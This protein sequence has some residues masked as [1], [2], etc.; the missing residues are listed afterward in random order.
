MGSAPYGY[1]RIGDGEMVIVPEEAEIIQELAGRILAGDSLHQITS[2]L[3]E[4]RVP[5]TQG[6][7][8]QWARSTIKNLLR[9]PRNAGIVPHKGEPLRNDAGEFVKG[10]WEPILD[11]TTW[12]RVRGALDTAQRGP[13]PSKSLLAGYLRCGK[14]GGPLMGHTGT[15][16]SNRVYRCRSNR[17]DRCTNGVR[18]QASHIEGYVVGYV[19]ES[20][21]GASR[22]LHEPNA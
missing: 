14:C 16:P 2:D 15:D 17:N 12:R 19:I 11:E 1:R 22:P 5:T 3:N 21:Q 10:Q 4:R 6:G 7:D 13:R 9:S 20:A 8:S 18:I